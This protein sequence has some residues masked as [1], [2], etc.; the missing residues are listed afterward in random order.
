VKP[1]DVLIIGAGS[2]GKGYADYIARHQNTAHVVG[3]AEPDP[4]RRAYVRDLFN[5]PESMVLNDWEDLVAREKCADAVII[6]TQDAMHV[7][8]TVA[9][10]DRGYHI[11]LEKPMAPDESGCRKIAHAIIKNHVIFEICHV[12]RYT[13]YTLKLKEIIESGAVGDI[14]CMQH[15]EPVGYWHQAHSYVRG[16]WNNENKSSSM[17]LAKSCHDIDWILHIMND[18]ACA[19]SSFGGLSHFN[20]QHRPAGASDRCMSCTVEEECPYSAKKIYLDRVKKGQIDWP[21]NVI[22]NTVTV[23]NVI[24]ALETGPYG[25][26]VYDCENDVVDNQVVMLS[27]PQNRHVT[28]CMTGFSEYMDRKTTISGTQG[29]IS[30]NGSTIKVTSFLTDKT[31]AVELTA[32]DFTIVGGHAGGDDG[33]MAHFLGRIVDNKPSNALDAA[34]DSHML[35]FAAEKSRKEG[36]VVVPHQNRIIV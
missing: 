14:I 25:R 21:V 12:L 22:T 11:L 15:F 18:K 28:F 4:D 31:E 1:I 8:P 6:A 9:C 16:H 29:S 7:E 5:I 33:L 20:A 36:R 26:C 19:V 3:V 10:A 17:L 24:T 35:V 30:G 32:S 2:R 27:F 23:E 13:P 34:M